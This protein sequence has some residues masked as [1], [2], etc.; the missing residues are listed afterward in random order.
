MPDKYQYYARQTF[1]CRSIGIIFSFKYPIY[2]I[3][4]HI[5]AH[6]VGNQ[7]RKKQSGHSVRSDRYA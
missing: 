1:I 6:M 5:T 7:L 2:F 4:V 3:H